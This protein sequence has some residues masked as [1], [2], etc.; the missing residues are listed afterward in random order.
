MRASSRLT[1]VG[2]VAGAILLGAS[3][4]GLAMAADASASSSGSSNTYSAIN[5]RNVFGLRT[6]SV[7]K[8]EQKSPSSDLPVVI[9]SGFV[10]TAGHLKVLLAVK[11]KSTDSTA[12]E[13]TSYLSLAEGEKEAGIALLRAYAGQEKI[14][15][16]NQGVPMT[17]S[18]KANGFEGRASAPP[19]HVPALPTPS[20]P[21]PGRHLPQAAA[22]IP[23][24]E[25]ASTLQAPTPSLPSGEDDRSGGTLV[26]G[27]TVAGRGAALTGSLLVSGATLNSGQ[28][29]PQATG[30]FSSSAS[31]DG[32][33]YSS[34]G[35]DSNSESAP[36]SVVS[37]RDP[38]VLNR[39]YAMLSHPA[40]P[41]ANDAGQAS[42]TQ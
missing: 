2:V 27:A 19:P 6:P 30:Q 38:W 8:E 16:I 10:E 28:Q 20:F 33:S 4:L 21:P 35:S 13:N 1:A 24:A 32:G 29:G 39:G 34:S 26:G 7:P 18:M 9:L 11:R 23:A 40:R 14:D 42:A 25:P 17:L 3:G 36:S 15:L 22:A 5:T 37:S 12:P 41:V 31:S